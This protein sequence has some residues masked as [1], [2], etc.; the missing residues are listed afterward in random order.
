MLNC[1]ECKNNC[2]INT[3]GTI[4][5]TKHEAK[6]IADSLGI[7]IKSFTI[8]IR[9]YY[10]I[11]IVYSNGYLCDWPVKYDNGKVGTDVNHSKTT[12]NAVLRAFKFLEKMNNGNNN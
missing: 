9:G 6:A 3:Q 8:P 1:S 2:C 11:K 7:S 12:I 10:T 5:T 4:I